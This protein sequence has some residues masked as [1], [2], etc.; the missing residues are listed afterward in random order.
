MKKALSAILV[1]LLIICGMIAFAGCKKDENGSVK[2]PFKKDVT[3][4]VVS[5]DFYFSTDNGATYGNRR[6]EFEVGKSVFVQVVICIESSDKKPH[7]ISGELTLPNVQTVNAQ[8]LKG[9]KITPQIDEANKLIKYPFVITTNETWTFFFEFKPT[10]EDTIEM[11]LTFDDQIEDRYDMVNT[12]KMVK[13][14]TV[15]SE[16]TSTEAT[17]TSESTTETTTESTQE[18]TI[19]EST[20]SSVESSASETSESTVESTAETSKKK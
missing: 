3:Y 17:T 4:K 14:S 13:A 16:T 19:V 2:N 18:S 6:V 20:E 15:S 9:Q 8:Y 5:E 1:G 7:D 10:G 11:K 12:I